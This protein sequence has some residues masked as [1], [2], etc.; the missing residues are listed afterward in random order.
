MWVLAFYVELPK[1][2]LL[3]FYSKWSFKFSKSFDWRVRIISFFLIILSFLFF[4]KYG[5]LKGTDFIELN[6]SWLNLLHGLLKNFS[7]NLKKKKSYFVVTSNLH[8]KWRYKNKKQLSKLKT[9]NILRWFIIISKI[10]FIKWPLCF[11][12]NFKIKPLSFF[13]YALKN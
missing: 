3:H 10:N 2:A 7:T 13:L 5:Y 11:F 12:E 9:I 6:L 8:P 1:P 4:I